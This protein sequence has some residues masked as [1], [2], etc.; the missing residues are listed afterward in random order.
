MTPVQ[1]KACLQQ[2]NSC[3]LDA[4]NARYCGAFQVDYMMAAARIG[5]RHREIGAR[6][7][8]ILAARIPGVDGNADD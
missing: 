3:I 4:D 2:R 6:E 8:I 7:Q 1:A 5:E